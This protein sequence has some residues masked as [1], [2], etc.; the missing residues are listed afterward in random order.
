MKK[1]I[2][3]ILAVMMLAGALAVAVTAEGSPFSDVKEKRW[4]Y[5]AIKFAY[6]NKLMDGV[7]GGKFDPAGTMTRGMVVTVLWRM[8]DSPKMEYS[9]VFSDVKAGKYYTS[10]VMW[11]RMN[12]IV[13]GVSE[14]KFDPAG[15]ITREQ[16]AT[17]MNRYA[18]YSGF[19]YRPAG[20]LDRF[21]DAG[22]AHSYAKDAL[23][24]AT[25]KGLIT[26]VKSGDT[27]LLDPRGNATREQFATILKRFVE[28]D[29]SFPLE[30]NEPVVQSEFTEP[31]YPLVEDADVYVATDGDDGGPGTKDA[32]YAT[33]ARAVERVREIKETKTEGDIV[34]AFK[35]GEYRQDTV[36]LSEADSGSENQRIIYC[37]YGDGDVVFNGGA[38]V[39]E[40]DFEPLSS[41]ERALFSEDAAEMIKRAD[42]SDTLTSYSLKDVLF[43][44]DAILNV[45][46]FP[47][48]YSDGTDNLFK[49]AGYT[50]ADDTIRITNP[51]M[52]RR[53]A[54]YPTLEGVK[55]YGY[56]TTGW[57]KDTLS[58]GG[59]DPDTGDVLITDPEKAAMGSLR[60]GEFASA[61]YHASAIVNAPQE[62]DSKGEYWVDP[63]SRVLYVYDPSGSYNFSQGPKQIFLYRADYITLRGL[64]F[65]YCRD[66]FVGARECHSFRVEDCSFTGC[67]IHNTIDVTGCLP[68]RDL[69]LVITRCRFVLNAGKVV[70]I[71][72]E[73]DGVRRF[74]HRGNVIFDNNYIKQTCIILDPGA[75]IESRECSE[76]RVTHNVFEDCSS[77]AVDFG[78]SY[79][80]V[81]E[82][83]VFRRCMFNSQDGGCFYFGGIYDRNNVIRYNLFYPTSWYGVYVDES[84]CGAE[85]YGNIFYDVGCAAVIHDGRDNSFHDNVLISSGVSVTDGNLQHMDSV[86][87]NLEAAGEATPEN[88]HD[89]L[90][91]TDTYPDF[92]FY[93]WWLDFYDLMEREPELKAEYESRWPD[94]FE[95]TTDVTQRD[96]KNFVLNP[97]NKVNGNVFINLAGE[98]P[99][100]PSDLFAAGFCE[101]EGNLNFGQDEDPLFV[102]PTVGDYRM[103][104]GALEGFP[105]IPYEKIGRY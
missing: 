13:N 12:N 63:V 90:L 35:A 83:N 3:L 18:E 22:K 16:L 5:K 78:G 64:T 103:R 41:E 43:G 27:D 2:S 89:A 102:N 86:W 68:G 100:D 45:A 88:F 44:D 29:L 38:G 53:L 11:A 15:K 51:M 69:D 7:G 17:M 91:D 61:E 71:N 93:R 55:L 80:T 72:P 25:D 14:G 54:S 81:A 79:N 9:D 92:R 70:H 1:L 62:L 75:A 19:D 99:F 4:S 60:Y 26:G 77:Y 95:L 82:Y 39:T 48:L 8:D 20:S 98:A 59:F 85:I 28:T 47:N 37:K 42:M 46:R 76:L 66:T 56:L 21:P 40:S 24:W 58:V 105:Y 23:L 30:W 57:A 32:P 33:M 34:V 84:G 10:A 36:R 65:K 49:G 73:C 6:D 74:D 87:S 50:V 104:D 67:S 97:V 94:L 96:S 52:K 101:A 31:E